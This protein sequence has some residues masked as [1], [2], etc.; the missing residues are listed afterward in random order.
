MYKPYRLFATDMDG[1]LL[2]GRKEITENNLM[3]MRALNKLGIEVSICTGRP[4]ATVKRY[5]DQL[6][7]P[8]WLISN[9]GSVIRNKD[10]KVVSVTYIG[11]EA[12]QNAFNILNDEDIYF[13]ASDDCYTYVRSMGERIKNIRRFM[14]QTQKPNFR[15]LWYPFYA[16]F[17]SNTHKKVDFN[18]FTQ[19][20]GKVSSV[21]VVSR[22]Y[23]KLDRIRKRLSKIE[24]LDITSSGRDNIEIIDKEAT[25]AHAL[26]KL[27][28][29]LNISSN[30]TV[31]VGDNFNDLSMIKF[32][33]LGVAMENAESEIKESADWVTKSNEED[34]IAHLIYKK[35]IKTNNA[36][37]L[38]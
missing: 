22:D 18:T 5:I 1:T 21:F 24:G 30:E 29:D 32:A 7:F 11:Q 28:S 20:G 14:A 3:A 16:V 25:K 31:A 38:E 37:G 10:G 19:N 9:N 6:D 33:G 27:L 13:H 35:I 17:F 23:K 36:A 2:N 15:M 26:K 4:H 12:I 8:L 34:G